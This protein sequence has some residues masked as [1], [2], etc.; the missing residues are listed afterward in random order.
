MKYYRALS[1]KVGSGPNQ[2]A[3]Y[4]VDGCLRSNLEEQKSNYDKIQKKKESMERVFRSF[5]VLVTVL[6][7]NVTLF[8]MTDG[9]NLSEIRAEVFNRGVGYIAGDMFAPSGDGQ[10]MAR[11][12]FAFEPI[13]K[14]YEGIIELGSIFKDLN[15]I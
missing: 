6:H 11:L 2:F 10:N 4:A 13:E 9:K 12:C 3:A 15:V 8:E 1:V 5:S 7:R 14:N